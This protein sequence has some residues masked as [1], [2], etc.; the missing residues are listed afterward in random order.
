MPM[1]TSLGAGVRVRVRGEDPSRRSGLARAFLD[2]GALLVEDEGEAAQ[3]TVWSF[4]PGVSAPGGL[5]LEP[6]L[7]LV[8][9]GTA[10]ASAFAAGA[11]GAMYDDSAPTRLFA[12]A[13]AVASGLRVSEEAPPAPSPLSSRETQVLG[14]LGEGLPTKLVADRLGVSENTVKF[15]A[16]QIFQKLGVSSRVEAL[17][18]AARQGWVEFGAVVG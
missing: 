13:L 1:E 12:A 15:H 2:S 4:A 6:T 5:A 11:R 7:A 9:R 10:L 17:G 14:L 3:V 8:P 18:V 16:Q